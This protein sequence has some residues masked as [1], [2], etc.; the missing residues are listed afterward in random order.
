MYLRA[1]ITRAIPAG[2]LLAAGVFAGSAVQAAADLRSLHH[3]REIE[4][5]ATCHTQTGFSGLDLKRGCSTCHENGERGGPLK[6]LAGAKSAESA[7]ADGDTLGLGG[8][9]YYEGTRFGAAPGPMVR[10]PAG[11]FQ[12][13]SNDRLADEGPRHTVRLGDYLIDRYEVTNL[14]YQQFIEATGR[15]A[16]DD[17]ERRVAPRGKADHP[18]TF[19][20]WFDARDYC[21][22]A[23]KRLPTEQEWE[24]AARGTDARIFPWGD[25]FNIRAANTPVRWASLGREGDTTPVGAFKAGASPY[26]LADMSGNV[27][28][29]TAS[30]YLPHPGNSTKSENFGE[31]YKILKGGS[32]W[33]CSFYKCGISAPTFN[34][35][36]FNARVKNSSFGFRC[37]K[38]AEGSR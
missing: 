31:I 34:R 28:E 30:W 17:F 27:W 14:Q 2:L 18:V 6:S 37:A 20:N 38:D 11:E 7:S 4:Q 16:P 36:F 23:G 3:S 13:G 1:I 26:G 21:A 35:S 12:M 32:W 25:E 5:C 24:K 10:I 22:W 15:R 19:V 8:E 9:M 29:W 33:D